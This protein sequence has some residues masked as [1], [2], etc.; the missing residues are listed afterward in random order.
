MSTALVVPH[1]GEVIDL[2]EAPTEM[3]AAV[4]LEAQ[5]TKREWS[6]FETMIS[7]EVIRRLDA[8][9]VWTMR[10]EIN[11][12][13]VEIKAPSPTAGTEVYPEDSLEAE[14]QGLVDDRIVSPEAASRALHRRI[15]LELGVP[16]ESDPRELARNVSEAL[17]IEVAGVQV[18]VERS[19]ARLTPVVSAINALRKIEATREALDRAKRIDEPLR[20]KATVKVKP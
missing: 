9:A 3:L 13:Q 19:E 16:W 4:A 15:V 5:R 7:E 12:E 20:R 14:L 2:R 6:E 8:D 1:T 17:S 11:G 18:K 10:L